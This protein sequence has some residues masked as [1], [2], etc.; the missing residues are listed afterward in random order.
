MKDLRSIP[1]IDRLLQLEATRQMVMQFGHDLV[2]DILRNQLEGI[3]A[4]RI[5]G[6]PT[7]EVILQLTSEELIRITTP[8]LIKVINATGVILHTNLGRAPL[9]KETIAAIE[10]AANGYSTLE[11]NLQKGIRGSR[12]I[13]CEELLVR[14]TGAE[15]ALV[16]NN[17]ASAVLLILSALFNRRKVAI[18]RSQL[19]EIGGS[20]RIPDVMRQSG[21]KLMEVGTTNQTHLS[22]YREALEAGAGGVARVHSSNFKII[23][24][25]SEPELSE[26]I[27]LAH[28]FG[29]L[30][31]DDLGSGTLLDTASFGLNHEPTIQESVKAGAD[32]ISF[33]GDKLLGGPQAGIIIGKKALVDKLK[34]HPLA[35]AIRADKLC[36]AGVS[37][38]LLHYLRN[39]ATN[40]IPVWNMI[41]M[42]PE[43]IK[44]R[45]RY[46]QDQLGAGEVIPGESTVGGGSLPGETLPTWLLALKARS[47]EKLLQTLRDAKPAVIG[48]IV[49]DQ[50]VLDPRTVTEVEEQDL[51]RIVSEV[52]RLQRN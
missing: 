34:K 26:I 42:D 28:S 50:V 20:F 17:N 14:L 4:D 9:S 8:S 18:S 33:S 46:W 43:V 39:E 22:D 48:R 47:P 16:V 15:A 5:N 1:S 21:A 37:A 24:F 29:C 23:G 44:I 10:M 7:E 3:R 30:V 2:V 45:A 25:S 19:V 49:A 36:L 27:K 13:H 40:E 41:S 32:I 35:R 6:L 11:Y 31:M 51:L 52:Y 12:H 38:N